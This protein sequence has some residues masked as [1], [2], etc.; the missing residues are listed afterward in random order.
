[1]GRKFST[2]EA[3]VAPITSDAL[4]TGVDHNV[5]KVPRDLSVFSDR[6]PHH[7]LIFTNIH[8]KLPMM[9]KDAKSVV[10]ESVLNRE[11]PSPFCPANPLP[12]KI[13]EKG[14]IIGQINEAIKN[15]RYRR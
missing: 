1:M 13:N 14:K 5:S 3:S 8:T 11:I 10:S 2:S 12:R 9:R 15:E 7:R 4:L 6:P